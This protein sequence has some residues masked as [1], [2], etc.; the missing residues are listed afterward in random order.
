MLIIYSNFAMQCFVLASGFYWQ[1][2]LKISNYKVHLVVVR[3]IINNLN[4]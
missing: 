3:K 2:T 1:K 4:F